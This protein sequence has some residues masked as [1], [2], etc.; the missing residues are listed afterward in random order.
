[1]NKNINLIYCIIGSLILALSNSLIFE[2]ALLSLFPSGYGAS[3][4]GVFLVNLSNIISLI[5]LILMILFSILLI[6]NNII[7]YIQKNE[8]L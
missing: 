6:I 8:I 3:N 7:K 1:M 5:G 2:R 4:F